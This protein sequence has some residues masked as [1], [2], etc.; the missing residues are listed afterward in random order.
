MSE[1]DWLLWAREMQAIA[2]TGLLRAQ[3]LVDHRDARG[4]KVELLLW[5]HLLK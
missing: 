3:S 5:R 4:G 2:Q 1:P